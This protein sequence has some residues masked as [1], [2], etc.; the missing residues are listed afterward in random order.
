MKY[1]VLVMVAAGACGPSAAEIRTAHSATYAMDADHLL[2]VA[3]EV[4]TDQVGI[5]AVDLPDRTFV[6]KSFLGSDRMAHRGWPGRCSRGAWRFEV[7]ATDA[8]RSLV[9]ITPLAQAS[10]T[11]CHIKGNGPVTPSWVDVDPDGVGLRPTLENGA[12]KM[13]VAIYRDDAGHPREPIGEPADERWGVD[14]AGAEL[15]AHDAL[16]ASVDVRD[17][18]CVGD[19]RA[20]DRDQAR[21]RIARRD[22]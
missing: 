7:H 18:R 2:Q 6:T 13:A 12:D 22:T 17:R 20:T 1:A 8:G 3:M 14:R 16:G 11:I 10:L 21:P 9:T 15:G 19:A 5:A 4:A